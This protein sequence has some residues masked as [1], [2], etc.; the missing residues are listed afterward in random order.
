MGMTTFE[1]QILTTLKVV[2]GNNK[3]KERDMLEWR[4]SKLEPQSDGEQIVHLKALGVWVAIPKP[5]PSA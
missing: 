3:L 5:A 2:T 4:T 1:K